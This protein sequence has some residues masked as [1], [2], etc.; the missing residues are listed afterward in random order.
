MSTKAFIIAAATSGLIGTAAMADTGFGNGELLESGNSTEL[1]LVLSDFEGTLSIYDYDG[2]VQGQ[3][4]G[5]TPIHAGAN[6][7]VEINADVSTKHRAL[8]VIEANGR[9]VATKIYDVSG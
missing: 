4:L 9:V 5:S 6:A 2:G 3:L 1:G 8:A 7:N